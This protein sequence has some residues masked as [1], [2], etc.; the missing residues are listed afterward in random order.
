VTIRRVL[1]LSLIFC[2]SIIGFIRLSSIGSPY[3]HPDEVI[4]FKVAERVAQKGTLDTNWN[5]ADLPQYFKY[6]QYNF[7]AYNLLS[8]GVLAAKDRL[9]PHSRLEAQPVL[10]LVSGLFA[11]GIILLSAYLGTQLFN[12]ATGVVAGLL[13]AVNPL[14]YQDGL[15]A[16]PEAFVT[17][18]VLLLLCV[19]WTSKLS[20]MARLAFASAI[21]G[22]LVATKISLLALVPLLFLAE[23]SIGNSGSLY[24]DVRDYIVACFR[25]LPGNLIVFPVPFILGFAAGAPYAIPNYKAFLYGFGK[26]NEQYTTGHW[27]HGQPDGTALERISYAFGYF[28]PTMGCALF[29]LSAVAAIILLRERKFRLFF[30]FLSFL[31]FFLWFASYRTFFERNFSHILP[32]FIILAAYGL[33]WLM[34]M[35][36]KARNAVV[37]QGKWVLAAVVFALL[38]VPPALTSAK[39]RFFELPGQYKKRVEAMRRDMEDS[40]GAV[41]VRMDWTIN[42]DS[43]DSQFAGDC[44]ARLLELL[45]AGDKYLPPVIEQFKR[46]NGYR[47]VGVFESPYAGVSPSTLHTYFSPSR[48]YLL[49]EGDM[50]RCGPDKPQFV[51]KTRVGALQSVVQ[52]LPEPTWTVAGGYAL[53]ADSFN[54][55][56]YYASWSGSD[57]GTGALKIT[58]EPKAGNFMV[59]PIITGPVSK[60]LSIEARRHDTGVLI[61]R[62]GTVQ[63]A[64]AWRHLL[65]PIG[66]QTGPIDIIARDDGAGWGEWLGVGMPREYL[67]N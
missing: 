34:E 27:P 47:E 1:A 49:K 31:L 55:E 24:S 6:P 15:Y 56:K 45:Y 40:N 44:E 43:A 32:L 52:T 38:A 48:I 33:T 13:V 25:R 22:V 60:S 23:S 16:R 12:R 3:F 50:A 63:P 67:P 10:R 51:P 59:L 37:R 8:G 42:L 2:A 30:A 18:L 39:L 19:L 46:Q 53:K 54:S 7:S 14:L 65:I 61:Y 20:Q 58:I 64:A 4:T 36:A 35:L 66:S 29:L 41:L 28:F 11:I 57:A 21:L 62:Y 9:A 5:D 26:L 17:L